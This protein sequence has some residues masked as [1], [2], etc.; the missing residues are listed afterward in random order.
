M[1]LRIENTAMVPT[2]PGQSCVISITRKRVALWLDLYIESH[3][4]V[5]ESDS[6]DGRRSPRVR[7]FLHKLSIDFGAV[8][9]AVTAVLCS[10]EREQT[11]TLDARE[12]HGHVDVTTCAQIYRIVLGLRVSQS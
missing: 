12:W 9:C 5:D 6:N 11:T 2:T 4:N 3:C 10:C 7:N 1:L 8:A